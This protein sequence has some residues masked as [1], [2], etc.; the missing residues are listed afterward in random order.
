MGD[1]TTCT[2]ILEGLLME[3]DLEKIASRLAYINGDF[4]DYAEWLRNGDGEFEFEDVNYAQMDGELI[5]T[6]R[7]AGLSY[8]WS[9]QQGDEYPSGM[10][11]WNALTQEFAE[12]TL[13]KDE[14]VLTLAQIEAGPDL[15]AIRKW[16]AFCCA[17]NLVFAA[18]HHEAFAAEAAGHLP[19]GYLALKGQGNPTATA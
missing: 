1:R 12:Y 8:R 5:E 10:E 19:P 6:L 9:W 4:E 7:S 14:I 11:A 15:E 17:P 13:S 16:E 3:P 2:L 18:S